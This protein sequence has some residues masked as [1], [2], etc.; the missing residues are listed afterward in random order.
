VNLGDILANA[1]QAAGPSTALIH[2]DATWTFAELDRSVER[3][4][5]S[6][7]SMLDPGSRLAILSDNS[8]AML[9]L[10]YAA[11]R[12]GIPVVFGNTRLRPEE[13][14]DL[15]GDARP[16]MVAGPSALAEP[17]TALAHGL[18]S[19]TA[20]LS[21]DS[22]FGEFRSWDDF[23]ASVPAEADRAGSPA[24]DPESPAWMMHTSGT[25]GRAKTVLLSHRSLL[26]GVINT[27]FGRPLT[28]RDV[29]LFCFPLFHVA[30][31]NVLH[32]HLRRVPVVLTPKFDAA[33]VA[34]LVER[35]RVTTLSLA[36]TMVAMLLELDEHRELEG[37]SLDLSSMDTIAYGAS[38]MPLGLL[39][40][41][42]TRWGCGF[43]QGYGMTELSGNAVFLTPED[44]RQALAQRPD[45]LAAAGRPGPLARVR[46]VDEHGTDVPPGS[47]GE[48]LV[49]GPQVA[50]GYLDQPEATA[51]TFVD[52]WVHTGDVGRIDDEGYLYVVDRLKDIVITGGENVSSREVEDV[53]STHPHV[54]QVAVIGTAHE[55][56]GEAVTAVVVPAAGTAIDADE[57]IAWSK[58][59]LSGFKSPKR[60]IVVDAL[61]TNASG[62]V[63]KLALRET[64][65]QT[66]E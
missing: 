61:P 29:Y 9:I 10:T 40:R 8:A 57:L 28:E 3:A 31:Y 66:A 25:T 30:A 41:A 26:G 36:P 23:M 63:S 19:V 18:G 35:Y 51:A 1:A 46:I 55:T 65:R 21:L 44:H 45:L 43:A 60:V 13:L 38:S 7:T 62:K 39:R 16:A 14:V 6:L 64:M 32:A 20:C 33:E 58:R 5:R 34:Q 42:A 17:L 50:V 53:L 15:V 56:W 48:I 24:V 37:R 47:A 22:D 12:A 52:G 49:N 4:A 27:G 59:H 2:G 11:A 54:A